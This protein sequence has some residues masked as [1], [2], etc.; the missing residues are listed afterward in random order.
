MLEG[1]VACDWV[2]HSTPDIWHSVSSAHRSAHT[3]PVFFPFFFFK[4]S[5]RSLIDFSLSLSLSLSIYLSIS[6]S[7]FFSSP[8]RNRMT[9][10]SAPRPAPRRASCSRWSPRTCRVRWSARPWGRRPQSSGRPARRSQRTTPCRSTGGGSSSTGS[11]LS[12][13]S[14]C[15][16]VTL[17]SEIPLDVFCN[18]VQVCIP[19]WPSCLPQ[20]LLTNNYTFE[21]FNEDFPTS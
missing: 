11:T 3:R 7:I 9:P 1:N 16:S 8:C 6:V 13:S 18:V 21:I 5:W 19:L 15:V 10:F 12:V 4:Y 17:H 20:P 14:R 2:H